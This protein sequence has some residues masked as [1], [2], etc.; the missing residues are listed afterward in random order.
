MGI[1]RIL[2]EQKDPNTR[3]WREEEAFAIDTELDKGALETFFSEQYAP[4]PIVA[5]WNG[6]SGFFKKDNTE[7]L[8]AISPG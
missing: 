8:S 1:V 5:P 2:S 4:T 3:G 6:G 7:A